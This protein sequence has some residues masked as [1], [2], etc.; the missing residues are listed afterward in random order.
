MNGYAK[1]DHFGV[2]GIKITSLEATQDQTDVTITLGIMAH[3]DESSS[4]PDIPSTWRLDWQQSAD[5]WH[6]AHP[7]GLDRH[8]ASGL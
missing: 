7:P 6:V 8:R 3:L 1:E 5:G 2:K 4:Y